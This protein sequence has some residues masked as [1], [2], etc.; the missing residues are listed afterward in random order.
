MKKWGFRQS[1]NDTGKEQSF[2]IKYKVKAQTHYAI[3]KGIFIKW[4]ENHSVQR[5]GIQISSLRYQ[6]YVDYE[7]NDIKDDLNL[8]RK[9]KLTIIVIE[10]MKLA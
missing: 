2:N 6:E 10:T 5:L 7:R 3:C 9:P 1:Y 8:K 4:S